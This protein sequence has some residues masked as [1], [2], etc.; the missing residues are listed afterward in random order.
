[1]DFTESARDLTAKWTRRLK[2]KPN[3]TWTKPPELD[4]RTA[5]QYYTA[6]FEDCYDAVFGVVYRPVSEARLRSRFE[7]DI[8]AE[9][10]PLW[11]ALR[12]TVYASGCRISLS[13]DLSTTFLDALVQAW[14]YFANA[15]SVLTEL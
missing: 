8:S 6:Y 15:L 13:K 11:C 4:S 9:E 3:V 2:V 5:L 1:M 12:N 7:Q 14:Q 10:D